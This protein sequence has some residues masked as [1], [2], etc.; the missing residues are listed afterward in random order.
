[1]NERYDTRE[2]MKARKPSWDARTIDIADTISEGKNGADAEEK[3]LAELLADCEKTTS[4]YVSGMDAATEN[5]SVDEAKAFFTE[6]QRNAVIAKKAQVL[7]RAKKEFLR[8]FRNYRKSLAKLRDE[9]EAYGSSKYKDGYNAGRLEGARAASD[10]MAPE[11][12][13]LEKDNRLFRF[14]ICGSAAVNLLL[15]VMIISLVL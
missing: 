15:A 10:N 6:E 7:S 4:H 2:R 14:G 12:S 9:K 3:S 13:R 11:I 1:M 5:G 8:D